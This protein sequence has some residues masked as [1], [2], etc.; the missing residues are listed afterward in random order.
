MVKKLKI[1]IIPLLFLFFNV[2]AQNYYRYQRII[3]SIDEDIISNN[4][5]S[6]LAKA[7]ILYNDYDFIYA[8][9]CIK[10][11]Q[12]SCELNDTLKAEIWLKKSFL[13]GVPKWIIYH[14]EITKKATTYKN[15][16][17]VLLDYS[18]LHQQ[19]LSKLNLSV[20]KTVDSLRILDKKYTEKVNSHKNILK[21][22]I[23]N[24]QWRRNSKK[25]VKVLKPLI[26]KYG[27][28][29]EKLIGFVDTIYNSS[30]LRKGQWHSY[31]D[32]SNAEVMLTHY[33]S[34]RRKDLNK[35]LLPNVKSGYLNPYDYAGY[36]DFL[37]QWGKRR[38]NNFY[39]NVWHTDKDKSHLID[40]EKRRSEIGLETRE[41][42]KEKRTIFLKRMKQ[43]ELNNTI[44]IENFK[45]A[46]NYSY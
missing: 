44:I 39:Y 40:I 10:A 2:N 6:A 14:N 29:G 18:V 37:G 19:H 3:N 38:Y 5:K 33:F 36:N 7:D 27:F 46:I 22:I 1:L 41:R 42:Q 21:L 25:Q 43:K 34:I 26:A 16:Q 12:I 28:P 23:Y 11:L 20:R 31:I 17:Q 15:T 8:R 30:N 24:L 9:H 32:K 35:L 4:L 13:Q 45:E